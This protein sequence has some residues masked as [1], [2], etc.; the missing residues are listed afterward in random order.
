[1]PVRGVGLHFDARRVQF[2]EASAFDTR[3]AEIAISKFKSTHPYVLFRERALGRIRKRA[4]SNPKLLA[5]LELSLKEENRCAG[6]GD[7]RA[8]IKR[9]SRRLIH[10]SFLAVIGEGTT[11]DAALCATRSALSELV[12]RASWKARPVITSFLDCAEIAVAVALAYDWLYSEFSDTERRDIEEALLRQVLGPALVAYE[13]RLAVWPKRRDN[14]TLVSNAGILVSSLAVLDRYPEISLRL[15][16]NSL[17][18]SLRIFEALAP[19]G[20]WPEGLSYWSLAMRYAGI[21]VAGLE[22]TFGQ[23]FGLEDRPGFALTGDFALHAVGPF[24]AAFNFGDSEP[25]FDVSPLAWFAHRFKRPF[26]VR[27]I[28]H[29]DGWFLPFTAIWPHRPRG[30]SAG[31]QPPTGKVFHSVHLAC[32]RNTW[33]TDPRA[34]PVYVAVKGGNALSAG[35]DTQA[36]LEDTFLHNQAD[37]GSFIVDGAKRRWIVDLGSDDYDLPGYFDHGADGRSGPRWRYYRTQSAGHNTLVIGGRNQIP[38]AKAPIIGHCVDGPCKWAVFDLSA[39]YAEPAGS[40]RRGAALIGRQVVIQDEIGPEV[41]GSIVWSAHTCAEPLSV[42]GL[43]ARFQSGKEHFVARILE[44]ETARFEIHLPPEPGSFPIADIR[45][46]HGRSTRG[47][48][49]TCVS[50]LPR[51]ADEGERRAAGPLIRR[52]QIA[53]PTGTRRLTVVLLPDYDDDDA[54]LP[55]APLDDWL[56]RRPVRLARY[57]GVEAGYHIHATVPVKTRLRAQC[58]P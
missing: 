29:Y 25:R 30:G 20:A 32:F 40:V 7:F 23:S 14:C 51:R 37:A 35:A 49:V 39:A 9:Q 58:A 15:I 6:E 16:G 19:D 4:R 27:L 33:S 5:R 43:V 36:R 48:E 24:G 26:D 50:E 18:S 46:L 17:A 28:D 11:R 45:Q 3:L 38:H 57:R 53:W 1:M 55:V 31:L 56:A 44:P 12:A 54:P 41:A 21:M 22:S 10:T 42:E 52:L 34:R 8:G 13:D 47:E 2:E